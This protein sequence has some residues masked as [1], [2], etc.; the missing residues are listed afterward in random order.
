MIK[1][2]VGGGGTGG[3][4][5]TLFISIGFGAGFGRLTSGI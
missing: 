3:G 2:N 5:S 1:D 4:A